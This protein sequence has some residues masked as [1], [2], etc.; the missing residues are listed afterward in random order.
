MVSGFVSDH[1]QP[2]RDALS[3]K[4]RPTFLLWGHTHNL[5]KSF[6]C[7]ITSHGFIYFLIVE[8]QRKLNF[9]FVCNLLYHFDYGSKTGNRNLEIYVNELALHK[10]QRLYLGGA[11]IEKE[12]V[13]VI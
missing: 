9:C 3:T 5:S 7:G 6:S 13:A 12:G 1:Q 11:E 10:L 8:I 2:C 4:G